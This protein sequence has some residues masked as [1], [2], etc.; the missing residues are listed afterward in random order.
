MSVLFC[1]T[2]AFYTTVS[3]VFG[4]L[5]IEMFAFSLIM[6]AHTDIPRYKGSHFTRFRY[7]AI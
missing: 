1:H 3:T 2:N 5:F 7:N 4:F 6:Y